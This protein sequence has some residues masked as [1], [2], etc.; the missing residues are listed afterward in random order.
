MR[1]LLYP[2]VAGAA[3]SLSAC[4]A[5]VATLLSPHHFWIYHHQGSPNSIFGAV[6]LQWMVLWGIA[7]LVLAAAVFW[8]RLGVA[9]WAGVPLFLPLVGLQQLQQLSIWSPSAAEKDGVRIAT[10][11]LW[12][13]WLYWLLA[14]RG[15]PQPWRGYLAKALGLAGF[16]SLLILPEYLWAY[17]EAFAVERAPVLH[18]A[19]LLRPASAVIRHRVVW[20]LLDELSYRQVY[21]ARSPGLDLPQFDQLA[22]QSVIF[23]DV[24][25]AANKTQVAVPAM[26][27]GMH[28][29][30]TFS[31]A[32]GDTLILQ[33]AGTHRRSEIDPRDTIFGDVLRMGGRTGVAGWY[34]PYCRVLG[35][36]LDRCTSSMHDDFMLGMRSDTTLVSNALTPWSNL[37][38]AVM[39][40]QSTTQLANREVTVQR[41]ERILDFNA[42]AAAADSVLSD[43]N[44]DLVFV[45]IP[46][47]HPPGFYDRATAR[48]TTGP[49][50]YLDNLALA[51]RYLGH[52]RE[53]L[54]A[55]GLWDSTAVL[56]TGDH[57]WREP[58]WRDG[59]DW[60]P[61]EEQASGSGSFDTRPAWILKLPGEHTPA[62][63]TGPF[64]AV[65]ARVLLRGIVSGEFK[66]PD[67]VNTLRERMPKPP[68]PPTTL[69]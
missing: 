69:D 40:R 30:K 26:M 61:Q 65:D 29:R 60:T 6:L 51:D 9:I 50:T 31:P 3:L 62:R 15:A 23:T 14:R 25:P 20:I 22:A 2:I 21:E 46:C 41:Q 10:L 37:A 57:S 11:L 5:Q 55:R 52:V 4:F 12:S 36:V 45:H 67:D 38:Q 27:T 44:L 66:T 63:I 24:V 59:V 18:H 32:T 8:P 17:H 28:L 42:V 56:I 68:P 48:L 39:L 16:A 34:H 19:A 33:S 43:P 13:A 47:P 64:D 53:L 7:S 49:A 54:R 58:M 1:S 35:S